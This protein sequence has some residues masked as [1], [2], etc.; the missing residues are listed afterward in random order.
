VNW[1]LYLVVAL[2]GG[3]ALFTTL[4]IER[5]TVVRNREQADVYEIV[6]LI[7]RY[8]KTKLI[9]LIETKA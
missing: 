5:Q 8:G 1:W 7:D 2:L 9:G 4:L 6:R 3:Y